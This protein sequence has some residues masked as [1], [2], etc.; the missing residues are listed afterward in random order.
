M[1]GFRPNKIRILIFP[2]REPPANGFAGKDRSEQSRI[3]RV[4]QR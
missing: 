1:V 4:F 2:L 3:S